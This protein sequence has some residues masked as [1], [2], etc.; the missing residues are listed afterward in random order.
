VCG[1]WAQV[2]GTGVCAQARACEAA[3]GARGEVLRR[4]RG[5]E[6]RVAGGA[7]GLWRSAAASWC[8]G[9]EVEFCCLK[10]VLRSAAASCACG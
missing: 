3:L 2:G 8:F 5:K 6:L 1:A 10:K 7:P 4:P 9:A